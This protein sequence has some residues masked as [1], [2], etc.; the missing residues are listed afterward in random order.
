MPYCKTHA[1]FVSFAGL[2]TTRQ[3]MCAMWEAD[4][5]PARCH[6]WMKRILRG[7]RRPIDYVRHCNPHPSPW[8]PR[9]IA[10]VLPAP[11]L[12][13]AND[14]RSAM[15]RMINYLEAIVFH[16]FM[17]IDACFSVFL[18][19]IGWRPARGSRQHR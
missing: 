11:R 16:C 12:P 3:N 13:R 9:H 17:W 1:R 7:L 18:R 2:M 10:P 8:D 19:I 5:G 4:G 15:G 6:R 14:T